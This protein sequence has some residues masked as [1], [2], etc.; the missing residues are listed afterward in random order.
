ML[1]SLQVGLSKLHSCTL[2]YASG[3]CTLCQEA[4]CTSVACAGILRQELTWAR[5]LSGCTP[6]AAVQLHTYE[7]G[8]DVWYR[9]RD[10]TYIEAQVS[11]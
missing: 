6:Q 8:A 7:R 1:A 2:C 10:G 9:Q 3:T 5:L 11:L 4:P